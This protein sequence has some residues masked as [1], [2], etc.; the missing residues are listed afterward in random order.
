MLC[1]YEG[2]CR[3]AKSL[4]GYPKFEIRNTKSEKRVQG[5]VPGVSSDFTI[6]SQE[7]G[8]GFLTPTPVIWV[9]LHSDSRR[10][11]VMTKVSSDD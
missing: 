8:K 7:R 3:G 9:V 1:L 6:F 11:I 2:A 4:V 10:T 5:L